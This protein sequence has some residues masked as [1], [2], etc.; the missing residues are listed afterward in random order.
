MASARLGFGTWALALCFSPAR[1]DKLLHFV[2]IPKNGAWAL[3]R[4]LISC[5][6]LLQ[7]PAD[8]SLYS[9]IEDRLLEFEPPSRWPPQGPE[10]RW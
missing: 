6:G 9:A 5:L 10:P 8:I 1:A 2:H 7:A 4:C 3:C